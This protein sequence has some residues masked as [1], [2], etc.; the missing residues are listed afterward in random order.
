MLEFSIAIPESL[1]NQLRT[2]LLANKENEDGVFAF[3][4]P[5]KGKRRKTGLIVD[6]LAPHVNEVLHHGNI[7]LT[8]EYYTRAREK[9]LQLKA[10]LVLVHTHPLGSGW[11]LPSSFDK[12]VEGV[13]IG[14]EIEDL[15]GQPMIGMILSGDGTWSARFYSTNL[16]GKT[17]LNE[18]VSVRIV[19]KYLKLH[20]NPS[21]KPQPDQL[22]QQV[23]T[24][25]VWGDARQADISRLR[26]GVIGYGSVG[27]LVC[28][29]LVRVGVTELIVMDFDRVE[30][31]NLDRLLGSNLRD[32]KK[33]N[34][35]LSIAKRNL[36]KAATSD[37]FRLILE[38][39]SIVEPESFYSALDADVLF[40]CVDRNWPRQVLNHI[41]YTC[42][43]PVVD[44][45]VSI[46]VR[47]NGEVQHAVV[48]AQT[49]GPE[50]ACL[51]CLGMYDAGK[52]QL[53]R[54]G[55]L[56]DPEYIRNL[57]TDE[58]YKLEQESQN[59]MPF[60]VLLS[61]IEMGQFIELVTGIAST[62]DIGRQQYDYLT[63]E[64]SPDR[65]T[66]HPDCEYVR[67]I[68]DGSI[69]LPVLGKDPAID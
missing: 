66:C 58:R 69:N 11:Q 27:S 51:S 46:F 20:F 47:K 37:H 64:M 25:N 24:R 12:K 1:E 16:K 39:G 48:R 36:P 67:R 61:G 57:G 26:I 21:L 45:G 54:D 13:K 63:G 55:I 42:L 43:I 6:W 28:E 10:G 49:V 5:A 59:I 60:S 29:Q 40:S 14:P 18:C 62:G 33:H 50:R 52:I 7:T 8:T 65:E 22:P 4:R 19:G 17:T 53:E 68:G 15:T 9:A 41:A 30:I 38:E 23:R 2:K 56:I 31:H 44:G 34:K 3:W 32:A 35:K